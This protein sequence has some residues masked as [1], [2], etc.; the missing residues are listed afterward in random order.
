ME[1][2]VEIAR[3]RITHLE[4]ELL[5]VILDGEFFARWLRVVEV[6]PE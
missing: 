5:Q 1:E 2:G 4:D 6:T 3:G